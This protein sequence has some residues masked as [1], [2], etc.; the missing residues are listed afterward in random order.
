M[1]DYIQTK[2]CLSQNRIERINIRQ[3]N[4][5]YLVEVGCQQFAI[6]HV[7]KLIKNL[8]EYL[9][10]PSKKTEVWIRGKQPQQITAKRIS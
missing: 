8:K 9:N 1:S 2:D 6:E 3:L 7:D 10:N 4:Y 5:G